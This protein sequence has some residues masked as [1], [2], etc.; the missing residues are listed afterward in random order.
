[1]SKDVKKKIPRPNMKQSKNGV[2]MKK[3][4]SNIPNIV[5]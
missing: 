4:K 2:M 1:M 3:K 5:E